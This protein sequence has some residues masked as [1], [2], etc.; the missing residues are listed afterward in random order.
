MKIIIN[1]IKNF[2]KSNRMLML[3][4]LIVMISVY[5]LTVII[6][7]F[8][9]FIFEHN[10]GTLTYNMILATACY[11]ITMVVSLGHTKN[12]EDEIYATIR[13]ITLVFTVSISM[14]YFI[15]EKIKF[16]NFSLW[17][18]I[19][20]LVMTIFLAY[21]LTFLLICHKNKPKKKNKKVY[22]VSQ[23]E[24][25]QRQKEISKQAQNNSSVIIDGNTID[26]SGKKDS[27]NNDI[28]KNEPIDENANEEDSN[29]E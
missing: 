19:I 14:V 4:S 7:L 17:F 3:K 28:E 15:N 18:N 8:E 10:F 25:E 16:F 23:T 11:V 1:K 22:N 9:Y 5:I 13:N 2:F 27:I 24:E 20:I 26:V 6:A 29:Y 21:I 12:N